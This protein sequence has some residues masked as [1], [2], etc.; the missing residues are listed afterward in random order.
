[1]GVEFSRWGW[2]PHR[3]YGR[4][5]FIVRFYGYM[6]VIIVVYGMSVLSIISIMKLD[7]ML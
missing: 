2:N 4:R 7:E 5:N 1:M 6:G 3:N